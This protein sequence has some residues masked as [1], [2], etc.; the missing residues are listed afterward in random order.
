MERQI[1]EDKQRLDSYEQN[2]AL[3]FEK[4]I[5]QFEGQRVE[6]ASKIDR[7]MADCL[8]KDKTI[9]TMTHKVE[10]ANETLTRR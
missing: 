7:L 9:A 4:Q 6:L 8:E 2:K 10:R 3:S 5:E 1:S